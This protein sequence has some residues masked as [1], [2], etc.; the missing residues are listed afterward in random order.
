MILAS[1]SPARLTTLRTIG[2][3]PI[4]RVADVDEDAILAA[5]MAGGALAPQDQ[6]LLLARAK[7]EAVAPGEAAEGL[8]PRSVVQ[9]HLFNQKVNE[10]ADAYLAEWRKAQVAEAEGDPDEIARATAQQLDADY[11]TPRLKALIDADG[12]AKP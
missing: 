6:V 5:A 12:W 11:D 10:A 7:A 4:V 8:P 9:D 3:E 2:I 1:A